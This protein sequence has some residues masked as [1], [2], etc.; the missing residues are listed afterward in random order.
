MSDRLEAIGGRL[1]VRSEPGRG[2]QV[3]GAVPV[4]PPAD[5]GAED[6]A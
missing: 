3:T 1:E 5:P 2:T 4:G 6:R